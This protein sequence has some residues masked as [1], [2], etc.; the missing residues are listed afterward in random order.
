MVLG[1]PAIIRFFEA[2]TVRWDQLLEIHL[3]ILDAPHYRARNIQ[4]HLEVPLA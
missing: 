2:L 1:K 4:A 3:E